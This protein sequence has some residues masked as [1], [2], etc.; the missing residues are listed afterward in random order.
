MDRKTELED[1]GSVILTFCIKFSIETQNMSSLI[2]LLV[3][4]HLVVAT[5]M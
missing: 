1:S 4:Y 5:A 3:F 2:S